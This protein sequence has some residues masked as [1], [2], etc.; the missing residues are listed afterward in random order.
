MNEPG[1]V[2]NLSVEALVSQVADEFVARLGRGESPD[3][4]EYA[5]RYPALA[6]VLRQVLPALRVLRC[7]D[8]DGAPEPGLLTGCLGDYRIVR[9]VGR[10]GMGVVYEAEQ[11]SLGRRVA[12]KVLPFAAALDARHLQRFKNEAQAAAGLRHANIVPIHGVGQERGVHFYAM[13]FIEGQSLAEWIAERRASCPGPSE[14]GP[15]ADSTRPDTPLLTEGSARSPEF[16]RAVARVGVQAALA[17]EHAHQSGVIHRDV[18]PGNL[19]LDSSGHLWV[20]DFGL[21]R[22]RAEPGLT[23]TGDVV[24]TLRY[25]SPE[26]ALA[27]QGLVDH[28]SDVYSLGATLY[29]ALTLQ[30]AYPASDRGE[31]LAQIAAGD[32]RP[33]RR[34]EPSIPVALETIVLK[35]MAHEPEGRY[36]TAQEMADDLRRFLEGRPVLAARPTLRERAARWVG[37]HREAVAAT[38]CVKALALAVLLVATVLLWQAQRQAEEA[39]GHARAKEAE[40]R[41]QRQRTE[42]NFRKALNGA[43]RILEQLDPR[44]GAGRLEGDAL[45]EAV[46]AQGLQFF[47]AYVDLESDDPAV[48]FESA[49]ACKLIATVY[50]SQR[51]R[52]EGQAMLHRSITLLEGLVDTHPDDA[53]YRTELVLTCYLKALMSRSMGQPRE[54]REE[55]SR[56][57][58]QCLRRLPEDSTGNLQN[59]CGWLLVDCP[60]TALRNPGRGVQLGEEAVARQPDEWKYWNTLGVAYYRVGRWAAAITALERSVALGGG[61]PY[62][63]FFLAMARWRQGDR[64]TARRYF[65]K[66]SAPLAARLAHPPEDQ[67]RY[68]KEAAA[69]LGLPPA[70]RKGKATGDK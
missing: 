26:Q 39:L 50:C 28:R 6:A 56:A 59:T 42:A 34:I 68:Q 55:F 69:L 61:C 23:G 53:A 14:R 31:L 4:E 70:P 49:R 12:L 1:V 62:N 38:V 54:A 9:E 51:K 15:A 20:A 18:K 25:M 60:E 52:D 67:V 41:A 58:E 40:A 16:Y 7:P 43:S 46:V 24:G 2:D 17:L 5:R 44:P 8:S 48:R 35:A 21:A 63:W 19:L 47:H 29:E 10:G 64:D 45:R 13:Q 36:G 11:I 33:P 37:R 27:R 3:V 66:A 57:L 32:P 22:C 30:P 65:D